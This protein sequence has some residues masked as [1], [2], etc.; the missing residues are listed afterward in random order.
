MARNEARRLQDAT[1][2]KSCIIVGSGPSARH[3]GLWRRVTSEQTPTV[4][5]NGALSLFIE[6]GL[7]PT[8]WACCDPQE[9]VNDFI[10]E[11]PPEWTTYLLATKCPESLFDR[12]LQNKRWVQTWRIEELNAT[13]DKLRCPT[14]VSISLVAQ[15]LMRYKGYTRFEHYGWDACYMDGLH[16]AGNTPE[17]TVEQMPFDIR[18]EDD[19]VL[20]HCETNSSWLAELR[21]S[22]LQAYNLTTMGYEVVVHGTGAI[23]HLLAIKGLAKTP[24]VERFW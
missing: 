11:N 12:L 16:H 13:T 5:L 21:D 3:E 17:P 7:F 4:A 24:D 20:Y 9:R 15:S 6:R 8:F 1:P 18:T 10:P 2:H 14:A 23:A 19:K 22:A